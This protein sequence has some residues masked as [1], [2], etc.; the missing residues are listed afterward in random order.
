MGNGVKILKHFESPK[1]P[2]VYYKL[3][4]LT[5]KAKGNAYY[6][7]GKRIVMGRSESTDIQILDLKSSREHAEIKRIGSEFIVSDLGSQNGVVVNDLKI[8]QHALNDG[9]KIII[10]S[11][12]YKFGLTNVVAK[13]NE[14]GKKQGDASGKSNL[15]DDYSEYDWQPEEA[16][17]KKK[18]IYI[19]SGIIVL[20]FLLLVT[21]D[22]GTSSKKKQ[23][24]RGQYKVNE[25]NDPFA[26]AMK[27]KIKENKKNKE[28]LNLYFQRG[29]REFREGNYFR[30]IS[31][32]E[33]ARQ[34][35]PKDALAKF[36]LRKTREALN[37]QIKKTF[38][39]AT[40]HEGS[41]KY[42]HASTSYCAVLRLLHNYP[43]DS[44]YKTALEG[45]HKIEKIMGMEEDEISCV[46]KKERK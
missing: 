21:D 14:V 32:F 5:G 31:E 35:S 15:D 36:Y 20:A 16:V 44:R 34:W 30:A 38:N 45:K 12:V 8:K 24:N 18:M 33:S 19:L 1:E 25:L 17:K 26:K 29:L 28:K 39:Q 2:G 6:L 13:K 37:T 40:R 22:P 46:A 11:T 7:L 42:L 43:N 41:L 3:T 4:C 27:K 10:G 9:D 23:K